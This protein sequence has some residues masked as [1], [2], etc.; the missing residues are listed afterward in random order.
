VPLARLACTGSVHIVVAMPKRRRGEGVGA[1]PDGKAGVV[2]PSR[3][4]DCC[5]LLGLAPG[6]SSLAVRRAFLKQARLWHPDKSSAPDAAERFRR[7][8]EAFESLTSSRSMTVELVTPTSPV[9]PARHGGAATSTQ[10]QTENAK[11]L[12]MPR[13]R[14][15]SFGD[16]S[17]GCSGVKATATSNPTRMEALLRQG[18]GQGSGQLRNASDRTSPVAAFGD[19]DDIFQHLLPGGGRSCDASGLGFQKVADDLLGSSGSCNASGLG[20][21]RAADDLLGD[22]GDG[23]AGTK[24]PI[25][26]R[27]APASA[28]ATPRARGSFLK[29]L[30]QKRAQASPILSSPQSSASDWLEDL[31]RRSVQRIH[32]TCSITRRNTG[33]PASTGCS[34]VESSRPKRTAQIRGRLKAVAGND[35]LGSLVQ[36][37]LTELRSG[38]QALRIKEGNAEQA[39]GT[40]MDLLTELEALEANLMVDPQQLRY[41]RIQDELKQPWWRSSGLGQTADR[42]RHLIERW[43]TRCGDI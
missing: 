30:P 12:S 40:A 24:F 21:Q 34:S 3:L 42:A 25:V 5:A 32:A 16:E 43:Q 1:A 31:P 29:R 27:E 13:A 19:T 4:H 38:L 20:F 23:L 37:R 28:L 15:R 33:C 2:S 41:S 8:R 9:S 36:R 11:R 7:V 39:M 17:S 22:L 18:D 10:A 6:A 26:P 14:R 35:M